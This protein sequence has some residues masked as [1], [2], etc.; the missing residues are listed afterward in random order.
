M[1]NINK[2]V[3]KAPKLRFLIGCGVLNNSNI[4]NKGIWGFLFKKF[5]NYRIISK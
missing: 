4:R 1:S 5:L 2:C 3:K